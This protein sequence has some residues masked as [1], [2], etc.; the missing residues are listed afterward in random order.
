MP[1]T[2]H[3]VL[4]AAI[5]DARD[6]LAAHP[7]DPPAP[8]LAALIGAAEPFANFTQAVPPP[9]RRPLPADPTHT[10]PDDA[11]P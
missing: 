2:Q 4:R 11:G 6:A 9:E 1:T 8:T 5:L 10:I 7:N 3:E